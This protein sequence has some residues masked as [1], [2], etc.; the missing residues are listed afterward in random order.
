MRNDRRRDDMWALKGVIRMRHLLRKRPVKGHRRLVLSLV[1]AFALAGTGITAG[2]ALA[3]DELFV[4]DPVIDETVPAALA[5]G[6][7]DA[8]GD[9]N[10][11][12]GD[13]GE[14]VPGPPPEAPPAPYAASLT[15]VNG[16]GDTPPPFAAHV[17]EPTNAWSA[18]TSTSARIIYAGADENL[19]GALIDMTLAYGDGTDDE[20]VATW[21]GPGPLTITGFTANSL[22]LSAPQNW[23]GTYD[24]TTRELTMTCPRFVLCG[25]AP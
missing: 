25:A 5:D 11:P 20:S 18:G 8:I 3:T 7:R 16:D 6:L 1:G 22:S 17:L 19:N 15:P 23:T 2:I 13:G 10:S 14:I 4:Y 24:L 12:A 9:P 21:G